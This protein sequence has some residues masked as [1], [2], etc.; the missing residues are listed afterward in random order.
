MKIRPNQMPRNQT[1]SPEQIQR[2]L[3]EEKKAKGIRTEPGTAES[4]KKAQTFS[5]QISRKKDGQG[6]GGAGSPYFK[7]PKGEKNGQVKEPTPSDPSRTEKLPRTG[8]PR[9][10]L[11]A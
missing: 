7:D 10:D 9:I 2:L 5:D 8:K 6:N 11:R 4:V 1:P 3:Q